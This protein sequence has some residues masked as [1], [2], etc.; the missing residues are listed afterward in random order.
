MQ[1]K[2]G[3]RRQEDATAHP[4]KYPQGHFAEKACRGC[5]V[6]FQPIAP[7][8]LYC[9]QVCADTAH[10]TAYLKRNYGITWNDYTVMLD[11]QHGVCAICCREGFVMGP[12]HKVKLVVDHCH[13][14]GRIRGLLCHNCNRAL[15]L[16]QDN[17]EAIGRARRYLE[18]ATTIPAGSTPKRAE[19]H[20]TPCG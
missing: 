14:T 5:S 19:A 15:G 3:N 4:S 18:G 9:S 10:A 12:S 1:H 13:R 11:R 17:T 2:N 8:H 7:S 16:L 6:L 20:D